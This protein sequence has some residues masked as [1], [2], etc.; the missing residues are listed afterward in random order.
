MA[1]VFYVLPNWR[2]FAVQKF[3]QPRPTSGGD[4]VLSD[5]KCLSDKDS[6]RGLAGIMSC[7]S[8]LSH[9]LER[10][11]FSSGPPRGESA[12]SGSRDFQPQQVRQGI[13]N[14]QAPGR[15]G[16]AIQG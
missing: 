11:M 16:C 15:D 6:P 8:R 3:A 10:G 14:L 12:Y 2:L 7:V 13:E 9:D 1:T 4:S 5:T